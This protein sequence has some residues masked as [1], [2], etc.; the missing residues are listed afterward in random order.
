MRIFLVRHAHAGSRERWGEAPDHERPLSAK[1]WDRANELADILDDQ[2]I[3]RLV[4]S[5]YLRCTQT[6]GP[7]AARLG[8]EVEEH[9]ALAEGASLAAG[10]D[11]IEALVADGNTAAL[12]SHGDVVPQLLEGLAR[13]GTTLDPNG[14]CPKGSVWILTVRDGEVDR[15]IYAGTGAL[16]VG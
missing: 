4:S 10:I 16:P 9:P 2:G 5:H 15:A 7:L 6:F 12:S 14:R 8:V 3:G 1:G 11:L 13:R